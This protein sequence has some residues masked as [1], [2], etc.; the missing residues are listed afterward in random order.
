MKGDIYMKKF[1]FGSLLICMLLVFPMAT[2]AAGFEYPLD[3]DGQLIVV[4]DPGHGGNNLG[5]DYNGFLEKEMTMTVAGA[6]YDELSK[7]DDVTI[8]MTRTADKQMDLLERVTYAKS[9]NADFFFCLHFNMSPQN[10]LYGSEVWISAF[11]VENQEGYR[12]ATYQLQE[13]RNLGLYIRGIKTRFNDKGTDYYGILRHCQELDIAG[14]L[15]EHC[16]IDNDKDVPFCDS[17]EDLIALGKADATSVAKYFKLSST[18]LGVSYA[19]DSNLPEVTKGVVYMQEDITDP[20]IC[21]ITEEYCNYEEGVIGINLTATDYDSPMLYYS[22]SIDGGETYTPLLEW[23]QADMLTSYSP[24]SF[25]FEIAIEPGVTPRIIVRAHNQ[26][27][28]LTESNLLD[29]YKMFPFAQE[30][31]VEPTLVDETVESTTTEDILTD[32][33]P[34][35][36][37][38]KVSTSEDTPVSLLTFLKLCLFIVIV[39]FILVFIT[40]LITTNKKRKSHRHN[41]RER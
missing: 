29:S 36:A 32:S 34:A 13:M 38:A 5:A 3:D 27:D 9:K 23:P 24:D 11:D 21:Y 16:H 39:L 20:D 35:S 30:E 37:N 18:I 7:Y 33:I 10:N 2:Q 6:M 4:I 12:Y 19:D 41:R 17:E 25:Q 26:Y 28:H 1:L 15:I 22:Y 40:K 31:I 8:Y 14:A